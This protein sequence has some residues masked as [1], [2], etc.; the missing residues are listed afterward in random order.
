VVESLVVD[1][2]SSFS[3]ADRAAVYKTIALRRDVRKGFVDRPLPGELLKRLLTS[4][5]LAP[6]V[7]FM[8]PTRYI[9]VR[10]IATRRAVY[11]IFKDAN[12]DA[13][14]YYEGEKKLAYDAL[15]LEGI[16]E[17]PQNLC[18]VCDAQSQHGHGLGRQTMPEAAVYSTVCAIQNLWLAA[19]VE[20]VGVGWVSILD[21]M[22]LRTVLQIPDQ[23]IPIAYLCLG[24]VDHFASG[25]ELERAGWEQRISLEA[26]VFSERYGGDI[27][28]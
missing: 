11:D 19:R 23:V 17:A 3:E 1:E 12:A 2:D 10:D 27:E 9:V 28:L 16:L 25:P 24:Y 22:R 21:P 26:T 5:H 15:K 20:G 18:I 8:Q 7:G 6:S 14:R 13:S 4:A